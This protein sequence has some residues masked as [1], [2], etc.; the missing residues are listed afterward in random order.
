MKNLVVLI[1]VA[2]AT[3]F[4]C[5]QNPFVKKGS[6]TAGLPTEVLK[7][8]T[9][10]EFSER[11]FDFGTITEGDTIV[12]IFKIKNTG[13]NNLIIANAIGSCGCT[14][15]EYPKEPVSPGQTADIRVRF[16]STGK[17][18]NQSK[19]VTLTLNT[20]S[21]MEQIFMEGS[22]APNPN[23]KEEKK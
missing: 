23:K 4:S 19:S 22:V 12:H 10:V 2:S 8:T 3:L 15:P 14:V 1:V 18:G 13:K 9:T 17:S 20:A 11:K 16:N 21:H 6:T 7:D 5:K